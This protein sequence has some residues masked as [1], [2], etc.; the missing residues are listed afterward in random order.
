MVRQYKSKVSLNTLNSQRN[1][2]FGFDYL[3]STF[4][5]VNL[6]GVELTQPRDFTVNEHEII[7]VNPPTT[8]GSLLIYRVTPSNRIVSWTDNSILK[9]DN[10]NLSY[11]Q[12]MHLAEEQMDNVRD[13]TITRALDEA[14]D[15]KGS[16]IKHVGNPTEDADAVPYGYV[17]HQKEEVEQLTAEVRQH[18]ASIEQTQ[19][20]VLSRQSAVDATAQR[21]N[22]LA[23]RVT[24]Q[25]NTSNTEL[26]NKI[27]KAKSDIELLGSNTNTTIADKVNKATTTITELGERTTTEVTSRINSAKSDLTQQLTNAT[28]SINSKVSTVNREIDTRINTTTSAINDRINSAKQELTTQANTL[29][30]ELTSNANTAT[31]TL[32]ATIRTANEV[33]TQIE[34]ASEKLK[35]GVLDEKTKSDIANSLLSK[36]EALVNN[37]IAENNLTQASVHEA[38]I[39]RK[40][41]ENN[42]SQA[43]VNENLITSKISAN[44]STLKSEISSDITSKINA[45][46]TTLK[47]TI[48]SDITSKINANNATLKSDINSNIATK[49]SEHNTDTTA[50]NLNKYMSM[51]PIPTGITDWNNLTD[52]GMYEA[53]ASM[54]GWRNAPSSTRVYY[55]GVVQVIK[56]D[57]NK[58]T[59]VF[60]SYGANNKPCNI[61][62]R[63]FYNAWGA[64]H[65]H[66]DYDA[67][68]TDITKHDE[69]LTITKGDVTTVLKFLTTNKADTNTSLAPTLAVVKELLSDVGGSTGQTLN[70][71]VKYT[72]DDE[73][74]ILIGQGENTVIIQ[75]GYIKITH[76][77]GEAQYTAT[78]PIAFRKKCFGIF[79]SH[80]NPRSDKWLAS[81]Q[82]KKLDITSVTISEVIGTQNSRRIVIYMAI[83]V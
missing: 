52:T 71:Q 21:T 7:L 55:Y 79:Y 12:L 69:G 50:H 15:V 75:F 33:K 77:T 31:S 41:N 76:S 17:R 35:S 14:W 78:F 56:S 40:I 8:G 58:L 27:A 9:A 6:N 25:L 63:T 53:T 65:Y 28:D 68:V 48:S 67:T 43:Q 83:G 32:N 37:R 47:S 1:Y 74:Y 4:I 59:Q 38:V 70:V 51:K 29:K 10:L 46:N 16:R 72:G 30:Q 5:H 66:G 26:T 36:Q 18:K 81:V 82:T 73:G 44:N 64:W 22:E 57:T 34:S 20:D 42:T 60:Y 11:I 13:E 19:R 62:Y 39:A 2:S 3:N 80:I 49:I 24:E 23:Q 54:W 45:N 61:C